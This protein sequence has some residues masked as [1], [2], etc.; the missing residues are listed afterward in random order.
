MKHESPQV[1][2]QTLSNIISE[3]QT[4]LDLFVMQPGKDFV[5][6]RK[7][8]FSQTVKFFL[9]MGGNTVR[10]ELLDFFDYSSDCVSA[11]AFSQQRAK[12]LPEAMDFLFHSFTDSFKGLR[13][14]HGYRLVACDGSDLA[15]TYNPKDIMNYRRHNS[16]EKNEKGYNQ[17]HLNA[18]YD[19]E[20]RIYLDAIIQPGRHPNE[21]QALIAMMERSNLDRKTILIAD[22]GYESYNILAHAQEK[23]WKYLIR[24]KDLGSRG[25][26]TNL[27]LP[28]TEEFDCKLSLVLTKKQTK[29]VKAHPEQ[30]RYLTNKSVCD[31]LDPVKN[32][33]YTLFFRVLRFTI[34]QDTYECIITNLDSEEFPPEEIKKLYGWRWGIERSFRELKYTIGLTNFHAKKVEYI[35]QEIFARLIIYNFCER[36][37]TGIVIQQKNTKYIYQINFAIAVM[38]CKQYFKDRIPPPTV[39]A[40]IQKNVL[41]VREGRKAPRKVRP[42]SAV[43]FLYRIA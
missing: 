22:R 26:I 7:L 29:E 21:A 8:T 41:P 38:I 24:I 32:P 6:N 16:V 3:M 14:Y 2:K 36:V 39:E 10:K 28:D 23:G 11:S 17:L 13:T 40:L 25:I 43:S 42:N 18:L 37:T 34:T 30:Y 19:L 4:S 20:N 27:P 12:V 9:S 31:F 15:I 1:L 5:R 33:F 35:L